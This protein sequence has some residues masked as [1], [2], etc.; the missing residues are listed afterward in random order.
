MTRRLVRLIDGA[1]QGAERGATLTHRLLAFARRQELKP[2]SCRVPALVDS[3]FDMLRRSLG[4]NIEIVTEFEN[5]VPPIR[6][7]PNQLELALLNLALN[8]R[9]AMP[10]GGRL[11]ISA[12]RERIEARRDP[13]SSA[14]RLCLYCRAGHRPRHGRGDAQARD[15]AVFYDKGSRSRHRAGIV[16]GG[17]ACR[18]VGRRDADHQPARAWEPWWSCSCPCRAKPTRSGP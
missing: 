17:R 5:A 8:A 11:T 4:P 3:I 16:D 6:V 1:I 9:D 2:R 18:A 10:L 14:R 7:D 13:R 15:R 12:R